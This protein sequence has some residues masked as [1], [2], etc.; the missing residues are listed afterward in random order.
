MTNPNQINRN[1]FF[2]QFGRYTFLAPFL[3]AAISD[4]ADPVDGFRIVENPRHQRNFDDGRSKKVIFLANCVVNHNARM[5]QCAVQKAMVPSVIKWCM[6]NEIGMAQMPCGET[7]TV[8]LGRDKDEPEVEYL[9]TALEQPV[10]TEMIDKLAESV[11]YQMKEYRWHGFDMLGVVGSNGSPTCGVTRTSRADPD[12][13]FGPGQGVFIISL[14]RQ[15]KEAGIELPFHAL[16]N[17]D[18]EEKELVAWL[19]SL[20]EARKG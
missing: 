17:D 14:Q 3:P 4:I 7:M 19:D 1:K 13:R 16:Q 11:V 18:P 10:V 6:E 15:M 12:N 8:G 5:H 2:T 20:I 9:R